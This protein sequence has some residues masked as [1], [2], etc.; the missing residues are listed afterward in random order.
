MWEASESATL[1][2]AAGRASVPYWHPSGVAA[3]QERGTTQNRNQG[4][5]SKRHEWRAA[6]LIGG[7]GSLSVPRVPRRRARGEQLGR[8]EEQQRVRVVGQ[9]EAVPAA[10]CK[11]VLAQGG[12]RVCKGVR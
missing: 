5:S 10:R 2:E 8:A 12:A 4:A 1:A 7:R 6:A 11:A 3:P 9:R